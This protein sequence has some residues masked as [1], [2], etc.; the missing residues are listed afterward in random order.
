MTEKELLKRLTD[1][2]G[3]ERKRFSFNNPKP[4]KQYLG[5]IEGK[6]FKIYR[7]AKGRNSFIPVIQGN[8]VDKFT[9][10]NIMIKMRPHWGVIL[11]LLWILCF[12]VYYLLK[13]NDWKGLVLFVLICGMTIFFFNIECNKSIKDL[14]QILGIHLE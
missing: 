7:N 6:K 13:L 12:V 1:T 5:N 2:V 8:I 10:R 9:T 4:N 11:F 3:F 14:K